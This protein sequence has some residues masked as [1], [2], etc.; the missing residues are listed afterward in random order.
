MRE[1]ESGTPPIERK[2]VS[3]KVN[4][5]EEG[6]KRLSGNGRD[7]GKSMGSHSSSIPAKTGR[8]KGGSSIHNGNGGRRQNNEAPLSRCS[9][10]R[11]QDG[12]LAGAK[13]K[14]AEDGVLL[15]WGRG[16]RSRRCSRIEQSNHDVSLVHEGVSPVKYS[17]LRSQ[18]KD[19]LGAAAKNRFHGTSKHAD[20]NR[21]DSVSRNCLINRRP[22]NSSNATY[23]VMHNGGEAKQRALPQPMKAAAGHSSSRQQQLDLPT[24]TN[25][26][27]H[28]DDNRTCGISEATALACNDLSSLEWPQ[29][30][31]VLTRKEKEDD[32]LVLKGNKLPQR[33]K[34]RP[35][36]VEKAL[37]Y[38]TPGYWLND[39]SHGR[40]DVRE[41]KNAKKNPGG[42]KAMESVEP[43]SE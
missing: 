31:L 12:E 7:G 23:A 34:K 35:K 29:I 22:N 39:L 26:Q 19:H 10:A 21:H 4:G 36:V 30:I 20:T 25:G 9:V 17:P 40:Y 3:V 18:K 37:L 32:F 13:R 14:A 1:Q 42:L 33:P 16:K 28:C 11:L 38:C 41:K 15:Q 2:K 27:G 8:L 24:T 43:D 6:R 5:K